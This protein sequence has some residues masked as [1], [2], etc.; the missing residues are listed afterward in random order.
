VL[1][2]HSGKV[3]AV[4]WN[5]AEA[6]VLLTGGFDHTARPSTLCPCN[7]LDTP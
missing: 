1:T 2:H 7:P 5:P 4:E 3:Q 6:P